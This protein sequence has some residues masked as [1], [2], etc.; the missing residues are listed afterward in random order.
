MRSLRCLLVRISRM[1]AILA[2]LVPV[3]TSTRGQLNFLSRYYQDQAHRYVRLPP[4]SVEGLVKDGR[5]YLSEK[6]AIEMALHYNL[7]VNVQRVQYLYDGWTARSEEGIYDPSGSF[8]LDWSRQTT[9]TCCPPT[10]S[11]T[12]NSGPPA[13]H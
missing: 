4:T 6:Q 3:V 7:G 13:P 11:V 5:L 10:I 8:G 2:V 9:P 12:S 1:L